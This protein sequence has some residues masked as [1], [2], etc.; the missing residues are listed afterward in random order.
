MRSICSLSCVFGSS[1]YHVTINGWRR[2]NRTGF[3]SSTAH[4]SSSYIIIYSLVISTHPL[5]KDQ[6]KIYEHIT[7]GTLSSLRKAWEEKARKT[8]NQSWDDGP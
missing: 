5:D 8:T 1:N 3:T 6:W 2:I 7:G 4:S